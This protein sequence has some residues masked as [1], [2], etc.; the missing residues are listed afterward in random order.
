MNVKKIIKLLSTNLLI[1]LASISSVSAFTCKDSTGNVLKS[2]TGAQAANVY[3]YL[4][5]S[6]QPGQNLVVDLS[7]SIFCLNDNPRDY[8]DDVRI[9]NSSAYGGVLLNFHGS[10]NYYDRTYPFPL[11]SP[12]HEVNI[13]SASYT[14]WKAKLY[15][16]PISAAGGVVINQGT[17][18][19][20]LVM[21]KRGTQLHNGNVQI[22]NFRWNLYAS[23]TVLVPIGGCDVS[24]RNVIVNL[25]AYPATALVP[26]SI[27]CAKN[28]NISYYLTGSTDTSTSIFANT[29]SGSNAAK[30]VGIQLVRNG[31][32][33]PTNQNVKLGQV[34][35]SAVSLGLSA[36]Y[37]HTTGQVSAGKV[38]SVIGVTF[39]YD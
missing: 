6:V 13:S 24:S 4:Q 2:G 37:A 17:Q 19:A 27:H 34:G 38:Q 14:P 36:R 1:Y 3:V 10:L 11:T 35:A 28:Q 32:A 8:R 5:P 26:L 29:L 23:N 30:G 18:F 9:E 12:T 15:L 31:N 16:T 20:T 33:I 7:Q 21:R 25:P 39:I 22:A